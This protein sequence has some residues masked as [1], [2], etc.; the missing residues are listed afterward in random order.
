MYKLEVP[1]GTSKIHYK[2]VVFLG[3]EARMKEK[4]MSKGWKIT[5]IVLNVVFYVFIAILLLFSISNLKMKDEL[6]IPSLFG[7]GYLTV[8]TSSMEGE[9][10]DSFTRDDL[11]FV[12][13]VNDK[14]REKLVSGLEVGDII[15]FA[16]YSDEIGR[17]ILNTHRIVGNSYDSEGKKYYITQGDKYGMDPAKKYEK[18]C[19]IST[20]DPNY[21]DYYET[22][23]AENIK[24]I[25]TGK[26]E[27]TG[28]TMKF[29]QT[30][31][32]F[33]L[34]I[35]LP[36]ALFFIFEAVVLVMNFMKIKNEKNELARQKE[37][38]E[39]LARIKADLEAE[40]EKM[41]A[42]ILAEMKKEQEE[43]TQE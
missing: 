28:R 20:K 9:E 7:K 22:I 13:V 32:G 21:S 5:S 24:A 14:N 1:K 31:N 16:Y 2:N 17:T 33:L 34:C 25:Y 3:K 40:K 27:G 26:M 11:I 30:S 37:H 4:E 15:T 35:V 29:L 41:R 36:T 10:E 12:K 8:Q 39:D 42:E 19:D 43:K 38:E 18:D 6:S 23:S